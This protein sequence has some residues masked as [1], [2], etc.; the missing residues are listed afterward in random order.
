MKLAII[1]YGKMGQAVA[2]VALD[3]GWSIVAKVKNGDEWDPNDWGADIVFES[4]S[5]GSAVDNS[6]RC[7]KAGL[8]VVIGTTGWHSRL[9]ELEHSGGLV[10][11]A[12]N[13]SLGIHLM[14][15][16]S[17]YMTR[18]MTQ[19]SE[20][21]VS[22]KEEHHTQKLDSPSGTALTLSE[23]VEA[24]GVEKEIEISASRKD[25]VVGSHELCWVSEVDELVLRH[26]A[27]SRQGFALGAFQAL[28]WLLEKDRGVFTMN[29]MITE[30]R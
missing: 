10:F 14:N 12:T 16:I 28:N 19:F 3:S 6:M 21:N 5:P 8:P 29:D 20:Y 2:K 24:E 18:V 9:P 26:K 1:G 30:I 7:I 17:K 27:I 4:S 13:F 25:N 22:I 11:Y 23:V 15:N